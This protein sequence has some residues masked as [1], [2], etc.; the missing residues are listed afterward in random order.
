[1]PEQSKTTR[2][3]LIQNSAT[4]TVA[5][6]GAPFIIR[7]TALGKAGSVAPSNRIVMGCIGTGGKGRNNMGTFMNNKDVQVVAVNDVDTGHAAQAKKE[8]DEKYGNNDCK[9]YADFRELIARDDID[10]V[11]IA[12]PD[13]WHALTTI[14]AANAKKDIYCEK[15]LSNSIGEGRAMADAVRKNNVVLQC[16]SHERSGN[17]A[18]Y[19]AELV[20]NG[21]LG[22]VD[23]VRINLPCTDGHHK[24]C[25]AIKD[26]PPVADVPEALDYDF[27]LGHTA[28][29]PYTKRG[30]HFYW[31]FT[32]AY[33]GGEMTDRGAH[34]IDL[35]QLAL[36]KDDTGPLWIEAK[37]M[38]NSNS[39]YDAFWDYNF[40][41][42][43][44]N[45]TKLIGATDEPRGL[46][47]EG[48]RGWIFVHVHGQQLKA[49]DPA[50]LKE[51]IGDGEIKV[52]RSPGHHR[53]FLD[54]V[55]TR[56][57]P[58]AHVEAGHRTASLCHL[59]NIA[60]RVQRKLRW[61]PATEQFID[62]SEAN[63]WVTPNMRAPWSL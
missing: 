13:H 27:W 35:A 11:S 32:L 58:V 53:N 37:G 50:I 2:R 38:Q 30:V 34:V 16:G 8:V 39:L 40:E 62:D 59:N 36:G 6:I 31:R 14:A 48:E 9:T 57:Q 19:V 1:M 17:N 51:E 55:K 42:T 41:M 29:V 60:M 63:R 18:R 61:D 46:K 44:A 3:S 33:G 43:Y 28:K 5:A 25:K 22:K 12:T 4:A 26:M 7:A 10:A 54:C 21:R 23:T 20:M 56:Q 15:P 47:F 24:E 45:G 49:S 52:G